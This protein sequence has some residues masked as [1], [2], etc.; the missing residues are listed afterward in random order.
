MQK[1]T[2]TFISADGSITRQTLVKPEGKP[3]QITVPAGTKLDVQVQGQGPSRQKSDA[4]VKKGKQDLQ[5]KKVGQNLIVE[6]DGEAL[7]EATD[8]YA[9]N[10]TSVGD[11]RWDQT[12]PVSNAVS[13]Q[14]LEGQ[15][16]KPVA[17]A[18]DDAIHGTTSLGMGMPVVFGLGVL[19][20][21]AAA[22]GKSS[23][24]T[25]GNVVSGNFVGGPVVL[26]NNL[27]AKIYKTDGTPLMVNGVQAQA[28]LDANGKFSIDVGTYSGAILVQVSGAGGGADYRDEA[29]GIAVD[30]AADMLASGVVG[31][32]VNTVNANPLTTLAAKLAGVVSSGGTLGGNYNAAKAATANTD[33]AKAF[34]LTGDVTKLDA[35]PVIKAD[36]TANTAASDLGKVLAALSGLDLKNGSLNAT[37]DSMLANG[38]LKS[39]TLI[40]AAIMEGA[41]ATKV[42]GIDL[43]KDIANNLSK[44]TSVAGYSIDPIGTD[45]IIDSTDTLTAGTTA[46]T[47]KV[48]AGTTSAGLEVWMPGAIAKSVGQLT[49][50]NGVATYLMDA[51]DISALTAADGAKNVQIKSAGGTTVLTE[52]WVVINR[53]DDGPTGITLVNAVTSMQENTSTAGG[54]KLADIIVVDADGGATPALSDFAV[55]DAT[56]FEVIKNATTGKF[57]LWLKSGVTLDFETAQS[58]STTVTLGSTTAKAFTLALVNI[59]EAPTFPVVQ[60]FS[61]SDN[62]AGGGSDASQG[63]QGDTLTFLVTLSENVTVLGGV[64]EITFNMAGVAVSVIM[65][66]QLTAT[67]AWRYMTAVGSYLQGY[68][69]KGGATGLG[70]NDGS[71]EAGTSS[72]VFYLMHQSLFD[73][74]PKNSAS[75][76]AQMQISHVYTPGYQ[77]G[78]QNGAIVGARVFS[79]PT[80]LGGDLVKRSGQYVIGG[81]PGTKGDNSGENITNPA[82]QELW[83]GMIGDIVWSGR[84]ITGNELQEINTYQAV[85]FATTGNFVEGTGTAQA[86]GKTYDLSGSTNATALLDNVLLLHRNLYGYGRDIVTVAGADYV[87]TGAGN[88]TVKVKDLNFRQLDGGQGTDTW[89][90]DAAFSGSNTLVLADYVSNARGQSAGN[91]GIE[92]RNNN[93]LGFVKGTNNASWSNNAVMAPNGTKT[94][95]LLILNSGQTDFDYKKTF[96]GLTPS[97][98]Y[99]FSF[100]AKAVSTNVLSVSVNDS[101]TYGTISGDTQFNLINDWKRYDL[102]FTTTSSGNASIMLGSVPTSETGSVTQTA[103]RVHFWGAEL[104]LGASAPAGLTAANLTADARVNANG[105]HKL[106]GFETIDLSTSSSAQTL[107]VAAADVNQLADDHKLYVKLDSADAI[108]TSGFASALPTYGYYAHTESD[109]ATVVYDRKWTGTDNGQ[110]VELYAR[111]GKYAPGY[112]KASYNGSTLTLVFDESVTG[113]ASASDWTVSGYTV[114]AATLSGTGNVNLGLVLASAPSGLV[115]VDYTG[116]LTDS[117]GQAVRYGKLM[118]GTTATETSL[119]ASANLAATALFGNGGN[120]VMKGGS[121]S[122]LLLVSGTGNT[123]LTGNA[124]ADVFKW[125][126]YSQGN[127]TVT[128]LKMSAQGDKLD[129]GDLLSGSGFTLEGMANYLS[130]TSDSTGATLLVD[131]SGAGNFNAPALTIALTNTSEL[132]G[133]DLN[134]LI[135]Q[136][137]ILT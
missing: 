8:F 69:I 108:K 7:V 81:S 91:G 64:P 26:G 12:E 80:I 22:S 43:V 37:L 36:G 86:P 92:T 103:G 61:V 107:T 79:Y 131:T 13:S 125:S 116:S 123:N 30:L 113:T 63:K 85:K 47:F 82:V 76:N 23:V 9:A 126:Q 44:S 97:T 87:T 110:A 89:A 98:Q 134:A 70:V 94:A 119:D 46:I 95:A 20:L 136:R 104:N 35:S 58:F 122:D 55:G 38:E 88:D 32:G 33:V 54:K 48:P 74:L 60:S 45:D 106:Y 72:A 53:V 2:V 3:V 130:W 51:A 59:D 99:T 132:A 62:N 50:T 34:G 67:G 111:S 93:G 120:D 27:V 137:V 100:W 68:G 57:E 65:N 4:N 121:G 17:T 28:S 18:G 1:I 5:V 135:N 127:S 11:L 52:R 129:L 105:F 124:G 117:A 109:G 114:N 112:T 101:I 10:N 118:V 14:T 29:T 128:D 90:L 133:I 49:V 39:T 115:S 56:K 84:A 66:S 16:A 73:L 71:G 78:Y 42:N 19:G 40:H 77:W 6:A 41:T 96:E 25:T 21:S 83:A 15:A 31:T 102:T 24:R 75:I